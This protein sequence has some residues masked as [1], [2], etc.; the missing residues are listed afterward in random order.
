MRN[1]FIALFLVVPTSLVVTPG[2]ASDDGGSG[3]SAVS[4]CKEFV[5]IW[6]GRAGECLSPDHGT[7]SEIESQCHATVEAD[8]D[9]SKAVGVEPGYPECKSAL[10]TSSCAVIFP[11]TQGSLPASCNGVILLK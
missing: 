8:L 4:T 3:S 11:D 6:C 9:C 5:S 2:C 10:Q 7:P 1:G